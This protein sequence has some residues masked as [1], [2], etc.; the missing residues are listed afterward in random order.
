MLKTLYSDDFAR[1]F[2]NDVP[3]IDLRAPVEFTQGNFPGASSLP[4]MTD[5]ER[6]AVGTCYKQHG[7]E[8]A[9]VL[10]HQLVSGDIKETRLKAWQAF[11]EQHP[12]G[13]LYCFRG[14][15][16]SRTTQQWIYENCGIN[17]PRVDGGYKALRR[18]L[19]DSTE[20]L[21]DTMNIVV[22]SGRSGT[23][24]TRLLK[25][26][27]HSIDL[28]GLANHRGSAFGPTT[29]PQPSQIDFENGVA[30]ALLKAE[31]AGYK[32]VVV[33]DESRNVGSLHV[34]VVLNQKMN[35]SPMVMLQV[36]DEDRVGIT[37]QEYAEDIHL[38]YCRQFG[39]YQGL[40]KLETHLIDSLTK[41]HKRLGG[42]RFSRMLQMMRGAI[43]QLGRQKSY[44]GFAPVFGELLLDYYDPMY[45]YQISDKQSRI[46]FRGSRDEVLT[47]LMDPSIACC[48]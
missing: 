15:L 32:T 31:A 23:G 39:E 3:M 41:L 46:Y 16:R 5:D 2:V 1:L 33:E 47:H 42:V 24:K 20:R 6:A 9:I 17:Y 21:V 38:E 7:Q 11:I 26:I 34:P 29:T 8:A 45:D 19:I 28:E 14:G 43:Q 10:G 22:L 30:I 44:D 35:Q 12:E 37:V 25:Q 13:A 18:F 36:P 40:Q 48:D 4:L 27:P